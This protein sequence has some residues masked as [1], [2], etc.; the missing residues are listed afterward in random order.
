MVPYKLINEE[1]SFLETSFIN[2]HLDHL[3]HSLWGIYKCPFSKLWEPI[4]ASIWEGPIKK[5]ILNY[6]FSKLVWFSWE[7][8]QWFLQSQ[9]FKEVTQKHA[10]LDG[11]TQRLCQNQWN[12]NSWDLP[13]SVS[14][15]GGHNWKISMGNKRIAW[16]R[17]KVSRYSNKD[18]KI[19]RRIHYI[20][21]QLRYV[22]MHTTHWYFWT[23]EDFPR[24]QSQWVYYHENQRIR[25]FNR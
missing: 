22:S 11:F 19:A 4:L 25:K 18:C 14:F 10:Q 9:W 7:D 16:C 5:Q 20:C 1:Q 13:F 6:I 15:L 3:L 17:H 23:N 21:L 12:L 24:F 8:Y 2:D